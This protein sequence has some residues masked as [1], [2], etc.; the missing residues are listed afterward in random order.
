MNI[1]KINEI[2]ETI[3][4]LH[5]KNILIMDIDIIY[6]LDSQLYGKPIS[7]DDYEKLFSEISY[8]YIKVDNVDIGVIVSCAL[9]NKDKI[10]NDDEDFSLREEVC[11]YL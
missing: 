2:R 9:E 5:K 1:E 11:Y 4:D 6:E 10:I 3:K 8:A 7:D